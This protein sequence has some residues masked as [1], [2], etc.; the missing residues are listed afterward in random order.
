MKV[1]LFW[2]SL[3]SFMVL[4]TATWLMLRE[5]KKDLSFMNQEVEKAEIHNLISKQVIEAET[6]I[7][8]RVAT[9]NGILTRISEELNSKIE[10]QDKQ[11]SDLHEHV[12]RMRDWKPTVT[13]KFP[14]ITKP[15]PVRLYKP[16]SSRPPEASKLLKENAK[17]L[18]EL[19]K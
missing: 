10:V 1:V 13:V 3:I 5:N 17:K 2:I 12:A 4:I 18:A 7:Q 19:S 6:R 9:I 15:I 8:D 14:E 16:K 11:I